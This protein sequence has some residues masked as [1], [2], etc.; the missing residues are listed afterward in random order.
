MT[1]S[2]VE[3]I[4]KSLMRSR[5][6]RAQGT[7][8]MPSVAD[9]GCGSTVTHPPG[10]V[11]TGGTKASERGRPRWLHDPRHLARDQRGKMG[12]GAL[13]KIAMRQCRADTCEIYSRMIPRA[14]SG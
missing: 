10:R 14:A 1:P 2:S 6:V 8:T 13:C 7:T 9:F 4:S 12:H 5:P 3:A 11:R